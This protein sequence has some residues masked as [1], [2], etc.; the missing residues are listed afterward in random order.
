MLMRFASGVPRDKLVVVG[1]FLLPGLVL[2]GEARGWLGLVGNALLVAGGLFAL[3]TAWVFARPTGRRVTVANGASQPLPT[4]SCWRPPSIS[5]SAAGRAPAAVAPGEITR[6]ARSAFLRPTRVGW[7]QLWFAASAVPVA[8]ASTRSRQVRREGAVTAPEAAA[9][10]GACSQGAERVALSAGDGRGAPGVAGW[11][12]GGG[13][14]SPVAVP[15]RLPCG[16][17][18]RPSGVLSPVHSNYIL[19]AYMASGT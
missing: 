4:I 3:R 7:P 10:A 14:C 16:H 11:L 6:S 9:D 2:T 13:C 18:V 12:Y 19:A 17:R 8:K 5:A 1:M 15:R